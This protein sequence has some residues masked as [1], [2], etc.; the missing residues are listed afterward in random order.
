MTII[1]KS[2][3][4]FEQIISANIY[5]DVIDAFRKISKQ[6]FDFFCYRITL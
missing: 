6:K 2:R 5:R 1:I 4:R 3:Y